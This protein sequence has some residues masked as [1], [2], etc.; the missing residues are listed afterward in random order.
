M[1]AGLLWNPY[2]GDYYGWDIRSGTVDLADPDSL[3]EG[4]EFSTAHYYRAYILFLSVPPDI[5]NP[6]YV[7]A[8]S[9]S[10]FATSAEA[11]QDLIDYLATD[12]MW[13]VL[14]HPLCG[15]ILRNNGTTGDGCPILPVDYMNR[16]RSY[17]WPTDLRP[18]DYLV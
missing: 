17:M 1:R 6:T 2:P 8:S 11:E 18:L 15:L 16:G 12:S 4:I 10:E 9:L 3:G 14:G 13:N 5:D 7:I